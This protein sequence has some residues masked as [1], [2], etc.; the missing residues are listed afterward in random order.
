MKVSAVLVFSEASLSSWYVAIF[1]LGVHMVFSFV[2]QCPNLFLGHQSYL[3][4]PC[5]PY[6]LILTQLRL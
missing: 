4:S 5:P 3:F 1:S 2:Y 6:N